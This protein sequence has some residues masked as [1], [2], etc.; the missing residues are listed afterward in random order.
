M[1][2][3]LSPIYVIRRG[4]IRFSVLVLGGGNCVVVKIRNF[5][6]VFGVVGKSVLLGQ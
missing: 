3:S 5:L 2:P 1:H 4:N 6:M